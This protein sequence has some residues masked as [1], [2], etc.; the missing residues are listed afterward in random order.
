MYGLVNVAI[1]ELVVRS[2]G[3]DTWSRVPEKSGVDAGAF[4]AMR[5]YDD[6]TT[7]ALVGAASEVLG[8]P[9]GQILEPF[10]EHRVL[11]TA[12]GSYGA[13]LDVCGRDFVEFMRGLDAMHGR[14]TVSFP[15]L[16]PPVIEVRAA[17]DG[18]MRVVYR[19]ERAGLAP[20]V[21]GRQRGLAKRFGQ[22]IET[23][24]TVKRAEGAAA[25]EFFLRLSERRAA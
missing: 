12:K 9:A 10:G 3:A 11:F 20:M 24:H 17:A 15:E 6:A 1:R 16:R 2:Y 22:D 18:S 21:V 13:V 8:V 5:S 4:V 23:A 25:A 7:Y 19:S 14:T